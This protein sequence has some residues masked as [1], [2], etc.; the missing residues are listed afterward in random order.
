MDGGFPTGLG[1][2]DSQEEDPK[3]KK[4]RQAWELLQYLQTDSAA[5]DSC[6]LIARRKGWRVG[7]ASEQQLTAST[8]LAAATHLAN[9]PHH[10]STLWPKVQPD[11]LH[12]N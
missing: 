9:P 11:G 5:T 10:S 1:Q 2:E 3:V 7:K 12:W 6:Q 8:K 4:A